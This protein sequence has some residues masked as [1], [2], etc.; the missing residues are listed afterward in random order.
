ML[1]SPVMRLRNPTPA[2]PLPAPP[3]F[4]S[5]RE[6][7]AE[8]TGPV[9]TSASGRQLMHASELHCQ[10][11]GAPH[12]GV[13]CLACER[14]VSILPS[15]T[16]RTIRVRCLWTEA[17]R[18]DALMTVPTAFVTV[19]PSESIGR[20]D[21]IA[22]RERVHHLLVV[23]RDEVLGIACRC[24]LGD[25]GSAA[26]IAG[27]V[28]SRMKPTL[29]TVP[30]DTTIGQA[31]ELM[32]RLGVSLLGIADGAELVGLVTQHDLGLAEPGHWP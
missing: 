8:V 1:F 21:L 3:P 6:V 32:D 29:W 20:A 7:T 23:E 27:T 24:D 22:A 9:P 4:E 13:E 16:R 17:D 14:I 28:G 18:V 10:R 15:Q 2:P 12:T 30:R 19:A 11:G 25:P 31:A 26:G 5:L